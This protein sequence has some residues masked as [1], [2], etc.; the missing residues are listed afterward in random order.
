MFTL[1]F[2]AHYAAL[3]FHEK[4]TKKNKQNEEQKQKKTTASLRLGME[5]SIISILFV[6]FLEHDNDDFDTHG[7]Y[8]RTRKMGYEFKVWK[9]SILWI[10]SLSVVGFFT[11]TYDNNL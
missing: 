4:K 11:M 8:S 9:E 10:V 5:I 3:Y 6:Q 7:T 2:L 1:K